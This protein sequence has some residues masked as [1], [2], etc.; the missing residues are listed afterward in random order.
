MGHGHGTQ[1]EGNWQVAQP[2]KQKQQATSNGKQPA[3][4]KQKQKA[5]RG[6]EASCISLL[7]GW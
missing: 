6:G 5:K 1:Q 2:S 7:A 4:S 3:S